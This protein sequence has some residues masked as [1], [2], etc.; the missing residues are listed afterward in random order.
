VNG[1]ITEIRAS[2]LKNPHNYATIMVEV[3]PVH[4]LKW[5]EEHSEA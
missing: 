1:G 2:D 5:L 3:Q 4:H